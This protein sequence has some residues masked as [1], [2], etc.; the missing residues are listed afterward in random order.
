MKT[1]AEVLTRFD[2]RR[3]SI[4]ASPFIG[5]KAHREAIQRTLDALDSPYSYYTILSLDEREQVRAEW[6][7]FATRLGLQV[8]KRRAP[9]KAPEI[10]PKV[11]RFFGTRACLPHRPRASDDP[12]KGT[13]VVSWDRAQYLRQVE[14]NPPAQISWLAFDCDH[15][16][17][18]LW[19]TAGLPEP[20]FIT[21]N[22]KSGNHH[23]VYRLTTPV[24]R[25]ERARARPLAFLHAVYE[26]LRNALMADSAYA[27]VLTQNPVHPDWLVIR[28]ALMPEYSLAELAAT[29]NLQD[30]SSSKRARYQ[31]RLDIAL[32]EVGVGSRNQALFDNVRS[33]AYRN[34][35]N[36]ENMLEFAE[37]S[38]LQ[39]TQ[40]L[41]LNEV[42]T[43]T[44]SI[45]RYMNSPRKNRHSLSDFSAR[46]TERGR[47]GGRP[48]K[49]LDTQPWTV[50]GVSR[51]TWYRKKKA[52]SMPPSSNRIGRPATTKDSR[53]WLAVGVSRAT[54]YRLRKHT[55][56]SDQEG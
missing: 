44:G 47:L 23:V 52:E 37:R 42:K 11:Q 1:K 14:L 2:E 48:R 25:S 49:T 29:L 24:C 31:A 40:P 26:G 10:P 50:A 18:D 17:Y 55:I 13:M 21:V 35:D 54:W 16:N 32:T 3:S 15:D 12:K 43:I 6:I 39:L 19:K 5:S 8:L 20:A 4:E 27:R 34:K 30:V 7:D 36:L 53:P 41:S 45:M 51:A 28:P 56:S 22:P 38:N 46:Q 33:W 9:R